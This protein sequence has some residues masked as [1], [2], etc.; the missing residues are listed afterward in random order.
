[1]QCRALASFDRATIFFSSYKKREWNAQQHLLIYYAQYFNKVRAVFSTCT[2]RDSS[3]AGVLE[4]PALERMRS[5]GKCGLSN[6]YFY[7]CTCFFYVQK[8][9]GP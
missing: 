3:E 9:L 2:V 1:M 4:R 8:S 7:K 6:F 5:R